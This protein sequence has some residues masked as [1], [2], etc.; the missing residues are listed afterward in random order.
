MTVIIIAAGSRKLLEEN[1]VTSGVNDARE[2]IT[3]FIDSFWGGSC[4]S[5]DQCTQYISTWSIL[6]Q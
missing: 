4:I 6:R 5:Q 2:G 3:T 1:E